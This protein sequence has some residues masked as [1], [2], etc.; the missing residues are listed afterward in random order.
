MKYLVLLSC[1]FLQFLG[2]QESNQSPTPSVQVTEQEPPSFQVRSSVTKRELRVE[3]APLPDMQAVSKIVNV[4]VEVVDDPQLIVKKAET[5]PR[6]SRPLTEEQ[7]ARWNA[8]RRKF[9]NINLSATVYDHQWT[10]LRWYPDGNRA[11]AMTAWSNIDFNLFQ[12]LNRFMIAE[13]EF[14][15]LFLAIENVDTEKRKLAAQRWGKVYQAPI[16]PNIPLTETPQLIVTQGDATDTEAMGPVT[17]M[18]EIYRE[19]SARLHTAYAAR[20][21]AQAEREAWLRA[22]PPQPQDVLIRVWKT[23]TSLEGAN[24]TAAPIAPLVETSV[25]P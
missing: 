22:N 1:L 4:T 15:L 21:K 19:D 6:V 3:P 13:Q 5:E 14:I 23:E 9:I 20:L 7:R 24:T 8:Q 16:F 25:E 11:P 12:G 10:F 17:A 18:H 2:A